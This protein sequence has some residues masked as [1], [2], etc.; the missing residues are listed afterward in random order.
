[1][2]CGLHVPRVWRVD[3]FGDF[4]VVCHAQLDH[5]CPW[6]G[7]CIGQGN[8]RAFYFFNVMIAVSLLFVMVSRPLSIATQR[9]HC[10]LLYAH[11]AGHL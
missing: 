4:L 10:A 3:W 9:Q 6:T 5:H 1:M 2:V 11:H 8:I 7:K